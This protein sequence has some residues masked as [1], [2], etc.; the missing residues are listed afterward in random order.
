MAVELED[1]VDDAVETVAAADDLVLTLWALD[2]CEIWAV[3]C[4]A[5][6]LVFEAPDVEVFNLDDKACSLDVEL[7][8]F[9]D[10]VLCR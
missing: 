10:N 3:V 5:C 6:E 9:D 1:S 7:G 8:I 2:V 4:A